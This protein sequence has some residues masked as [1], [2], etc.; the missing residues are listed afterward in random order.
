M[1]RFRCEGSDL[2]LNFGLADVGLPQDTYE[3][4]KVQLR[5]FRG[6]DGIALE[7]RDGGQFVG[8]VE[9]LSVGQRYDVRII[10]DNRTDQYDVY[11]QGP[12][13]TES[14]VGEGIDFRRPGDQPLRALFVKSHD[15]EG[16]D[17]VFFDDIRLK[18]VAKHTTSAGATN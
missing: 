13:A 1:L 6:V 12:E 4:F 9:G 16:G 15:G 11:L 5:L 18:H 2:N 14:L 10:I 17:A 3:D 8:L 7:V